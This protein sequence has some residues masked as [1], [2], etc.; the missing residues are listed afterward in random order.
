MFPTFPLF[1]IAD[2]YKVH[3]FFTKYLG[4]LH[5]PVHQW[6]SSLRTRAGYPPFEDD[7]DSSAFHL[8][9]HSAES[10]SSVIEAHN[11]GS[12]TSWRSARPEYHFEIAIT[13]EDSNASFPLTG[14]QFERV[15]STFSLWSFS[16]LT[17]PEICD[18]LSADLE[19]T[20]EKISPAMFL[21][22]I[23]QSRQRSD[24]HQK[25]L[26]ESPH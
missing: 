19:W 3:N 21:K 18:E 4:T 20:D 12:A 25:Y 16:L 26:H 23:A 2:V 5:D 17:V 1:A 15:S 13:T 22:T 8:T 9:A 7:R 6:T 11:H 24:T 10:L 14:A